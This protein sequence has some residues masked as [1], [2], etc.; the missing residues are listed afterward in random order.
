[1]LPTH[2]EKLNYGTLWL[3]EPGDSK[4]GKKI[5]EL[6]NLEDSIPIEEELQYFIEDRKLNVKNNIKPA[7]EKGTI[8][9]V[10]RY[11]LSSACYQG[12]R[13]MD[14]IDIIRKNRE[15]A[16]EPDVTFIIDVDVDTA[17][18]RI[19]KGRD[20]E[21]KLF[22]KKEYLQTVRSNYLEFK[23]NKNIYVVDGT[24]SPEAVFEDVIQILDD[25]L[26]GSKPHPKATGG[27]TGEAAHGL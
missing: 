11:Y 21:A 10:D 23:R 17:L 8:V 9:I 22:E 3:R 18:A 4:W 13:G 6:A 5:R 24:R 20:V 7:L 25:C 26:G 2:L 12:A 14:K 27:E 1:M 19:K 16:P 15:F